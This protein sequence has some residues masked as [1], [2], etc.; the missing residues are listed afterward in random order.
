MNVGAARPED[1]GTYYAWGETTPK[2]EYSWDTYKWCEG[3]DGS[4]QNRHLTKYNPDSGYGKVDGK[5]TLEIGDDAAHQTLSGKWRMP[6]KAEFQ[7]LVDNCK[8]KWGKVD[9]V[10]G[11]LVTSKIPGRTKNSIF[12]PATGIRYG[13]ESLNAGE[14]SCYWSSTEDESEPNRAYYLDIAKKS[15]GADAFYR[16]YGYPIRAV[17]DDSLDESATQAAPVQS[18]S[19]QEEEIEDGLGD[20]PDEYFDPI[21]IES[22]EAGTLGNLLSGWSPDEVTELVVSGALDARD[23]NTMKSTYKNLSYLD[24]SDARIAAYHGDGGTDA[25]TSDYKENELPLGA[26]FYWVPV[27][28]GMPS[29]TEVHLPKS[30]TAI[31][32]NAFARAYNITMIEIP[33]GVRSIGYVS[34][35]ICTSLQNVDLPTTLTSIGK[36]AF[37]SDK[38]ILR[39]NCHAIDP[40]AL[41][42]GVFNCPKAELHVPEGYE[43]VYAES[44]WGKHFSYIKDDL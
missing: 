16:F 19:T 17:W 6:T 3:Y 11:Y 43:E 38:N 21:C 42:E 41:E 31:G 18:D 8:W 13:S 36:Q 34:F 37:S 12:L 5:S 20:D 9:G 25:N 44:E 1:S 10:Y 27:D 14:S 2:S 15:H 40:P 22:S 7:E 39:V 29:L 26:F 28:E 33:E 23:F 4:V 24:M 32:R 35:A 30:I